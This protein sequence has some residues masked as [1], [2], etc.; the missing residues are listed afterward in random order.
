MKKNT[1]KP[2]FIRNWML[3]LVGIF[4]SFGV[5]DAQIKVSG[6]VTDS[7]SEPLIGVNITISGTRTGTITDFNG[8]YTIEAPD[9]KSVLIFSYI[10]YKTML[11]DAGTTGVI[12]VTLVEDALQMEDV[13]VVAYG[14][15]KKSH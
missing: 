12:N 13:I 14:T 2:Q 9:S 3:V 15:Q 7:N 11:R 8:A 4:A 10:G 1:N 6:T 5:L